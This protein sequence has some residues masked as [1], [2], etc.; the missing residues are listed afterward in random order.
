MPEL[1]TKSDSVL[2]AITGLLDA[3]HSNNILY[4]HWK[5]NEH[6]A[7]SMSGDTDLDVLFDEK[8]KEQ[9]ESILHG[10]GFKRFD[11]IKQKQYKDIVDFLC[12][13]DGSG[14]IIHLHTH[15]RL[16]MGEP[17]LK[18]YQL[19]LEPTILNTRVFSDQFGIYCT[20]PSMELILLF[21]RESLKIRHRDILLMH[22][23]NKIEYGE[24]ILREYNWLKTATSN[25]EIHEMLNC[26]FDADQTQIY[27]FVTSEFNRK[28]LR[29]L[30]PLLR[31]KFRS[32]RLYSPLSALIHRWY[33]EGTIV[34][35]RK[36]ARLLALPILSKRVN[37][38]GGIIV[39]VV[40]ADGSGKS[41][42]TA[43]LMNTFSTKLDVFKIYF[44]RGDGKVSWSRKVLLSLR[45]ITEPAGRSKGRV[46][47]THQN[48]S[49]KMGF[50]RAIY[51]CL[52]ATLVAREKSSNLK[53]MTK[54]KKKGALVICDRFPQNQVMGFNDG[55][56]LNGFMHKGNFLYRAFARMESRV[57]EK[58][59]NTP[60]DILFKLI[61]SA[62]VV[63]KRKP[64]ETSLEKLE[65]K[66]DGIRQLSLKNSCKV[67]TIDAT[68]PLSN[69]LS[70]VKREIWQTL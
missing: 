47:N 35:A 22:L 36:L 23:K 50:V 12:L 20:A 48:K 27:Q 40:G 25:D 59:D 62:D 38:R 42:V 26:I 65:E 18:G 30:A 67:I 41:T 34:S 49:S 24:S 37:P 56:L 31:E 29:K 17:Y 70:T 10:L 64:G 57:Y 60:P 33:R 16:T 43:N 61:A 14:K 15:Y 52:E 21:I 19:D 13:D 3:L 2:A 46:N 55:P 8:Q 45:R 5:S 44:G 32:K 51:K 68:M 7:A 4:C 39:A 1:R 28:Q 58:A 9:V 66:I 6:L 69:V 63:E 53:K 11:A 54:A